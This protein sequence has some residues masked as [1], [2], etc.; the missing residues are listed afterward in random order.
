MQPPPLSAKVLRKAVRATGQ[1]WWLRL[2]LTFGEQYAVQPSD[3]RGR[4]NAVCRDL[5]HRGIET[6]VFARGTGRTAHLGRRIRLQGARHAEH[7]GPLVEHCIA[8]LVVIG[9][10]R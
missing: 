4:R 10:E 8:R 3:L 7:V 9:P 2:Q 1:V 6:T 5:V